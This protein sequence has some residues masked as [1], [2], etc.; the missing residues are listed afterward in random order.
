MPPGVATLSE[1]LK[2]LSP[3]N[4]SHPDVKETPLGI[5]GIGRH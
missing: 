5:P 2:I 1:P 3:V 4:R